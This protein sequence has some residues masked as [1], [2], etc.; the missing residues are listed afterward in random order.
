[1]RKLLKK[2]AGINYRHYLCAALCLISVA[3]TAWV[4]PYAL[5]RLIE[6]FRDLALSIAYYFCELIGIKHSIAPTVTAFS[7]FPFTMP[8][9]FPET[10]AEFKTAFSTYWKVFASG[11][12]VKA[13]FRAV[14]LF[15]SN[16]AK[17][18]ILF[19]PLVL[20]LVLLVRRTLSSENNDYNKD[21]KPLRIHKKISQKV[22]RP[23]WRWLVSCYT[24][25]REHVKYGKFL[26]FVWLLN[27]NLLAIFIA[28][29]AF[30]FYFVVKFDFIEIYVQVRKLFM[31]LSVMLNFVPAPV[32]VILGIV[33]FDWLRKKWAYARLNHFEHR[34]RGYINER[35]IVFMVVGTMGKKKTTM[36]T[37]MV[38]STEVMF[39]DKAFEKLL[40][41]DLKFPYFPWINLEQ[42]LRRAIER[43]SVYNLAT[44]KRFVYGKYRKWLKRPTSYNLFGYDYKRYGLTYDD[45]LTVIDVWQAIETYV[46]L[47]FI[48]VMQSSLLISNYS[49]RTDNVLED[50]GNFPL[51][52]TDFFKRDSRLME[53]Y[54]RHA[55]ILD[56]DMLR[57]GRKIVEDNRFRDTF[58]FGVI[59]LT[60]IGKERQNSLELRE[61]KK[62]VDETNQKNDLFNAW[63]KMVRHSATVDNFPFVKVITDEQRPESWGADARDLCEIVH[64][65]SCSEMGLAM[66]FFALEELLHGFFFNKF[67]DTYYQYRFYRGDN[68]LLMHLI[69]TVSAGF[70]RYYT[71]IYNRF[72]VMQVAT[73]VE[74]GTQ[75]GERKQGKYYLMAKKI[76][77]KRFSTD[78]FADYFNEKALRSMLGL[79]DV[80]SF[81]TERASLNE[82]IS[83]NSYFFNDLMKIR[84]EYG[85]EKK[86]KKE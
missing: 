4:F 55:H 47:Y 28:F 45:K 66:P 3:C 71:R 15:L 25:F 70:H 54:S 35:P 1:M 22:Y 40:E 74:A 39:R 23:M 77:S 65:D 79:N 24:F 52:N 78:C 14:A 20:L 81:A 32:W 8:F 59:S 58:E 38:L 64:I 9:D 62:N 61:L 69:K 41:T 85:A 34:N 16:A 83:E 46:Q 30:Y 49:V 31:D 84:T 29:L 13:Y 48:Y 60:E 12:N 10:W 44:C 67:S 18:I 72:G 5:P 53:S 86:D 51:W 36:V 33:V 76:Y 50:L 37:D 27:F 21:S 73:G 11:E 82:M 63:L 75:D 26:L 56:F 19:A 43:H 80:P 7:K 2:I 42:S 57:L 17:W 68:T 6:T